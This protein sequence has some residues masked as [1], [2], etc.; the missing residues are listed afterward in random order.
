M[1]SL[2]KG[3]YGNK[4][5]V[6]CFIST[7][8]SLTTHALV[9]LTIFWLMW[10]KAWRPRYLGWKNR[11]NFAFKTRLKNSE[12]HHTWHQKKFPNLIYLPLWI[13]EMFPNPL[14]RCWLMKSENVVD[15]HQSN[16]SKLLLYL[17]C[18]IGKH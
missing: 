8:S 10:T 1:K 2:H 9:L 7:R 16:I 17:A 13:Q 5:L 4:L 18:Y 12:C 15:Q 6:T 14:I 3:S 11:T